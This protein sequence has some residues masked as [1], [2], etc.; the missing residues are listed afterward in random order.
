M[1]DQRVQQLRVLEIGGAAAGYC[2]RLF[3]GDADVVHVRGPTPPAWCDEVALDLYLHAGKR[4][5]ESADPALWGQLAQAA[6][7]VVLEAP[8]AD[9]VTAAGFDD[10]S[11]P[12]KVAI[13]PF[14]RTGPK[15]NWHATP[16]TV[17]AMGG[18][19]FLMGDADRQPLTLPGHYLEFQ[20]GALAYTA[21]SACLRDKQT[22]DIDIGLLE[23]LMALSQFTTVRWHCAADIRSR[24]GSDF[25]FVTPSELFRALDG[26]VY[27]NIVPT[28]WDAFTVFLERPDLLLDARFT[29]NDDRAA[30]REVLHREIAAVVSELTV[31]ELVRRSESSRIPMGVVMS[32]DEVLADPH[33]AARGFFTPLVTEHGTLQQPGLPFHI[34]GAAR[35][36]RPPARIWSGSQW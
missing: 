10:W 21:A 32:F 3:A 25:F 16:S 17:L 5:V 11:T 36:A 13:T 1:T 27:V 6:D 19:T 20:A 24:H 26:W 29:S 28:F 31:E 12:I 4:F 2:G 33:L 7:V 22:N 14:G 18:Y 30:H 23:T 15:R 9:A 8:D 35:A 34:H